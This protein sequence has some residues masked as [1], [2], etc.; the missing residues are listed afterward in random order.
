MHY[1]TFSFDYKALTDEQVIAEIVRF[2][3]AS[4]P[5]SLAEFSYL[6]TMFVEDCNVAKKKSTLEK[7]LEEMLKI[8]ANHARISSILRTTMSTRNAISNWYTT[9][10]QA[11]AILEREDPERAQRLMIGL[12]ESDPN[13]PEEMDGL[14]AWSSIIKRV[15]QYT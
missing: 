1:V 4:H 2:A 14:D 8:R 6:A 11:L 12:L 9:R 5:E 13:T 3:H 15:R 7:L 10:D